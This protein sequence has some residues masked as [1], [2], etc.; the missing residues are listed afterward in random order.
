MGES[1]ALLGAA[2]DG[3]EL[4]VGVPAPEL[5]AGSFVAGPLPA[6]ISLGSVAG[7]VLLPP[8]LPLS[9]AAL[10]LT[11][12]GCPS[13]VFL[14]AEVLDFATDKASKS[15]LIPSYLN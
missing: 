3:C 1:L 4:S 11:E 9:A 10:F 8:A 5:C 14:V 7:G 13:G 2:D 6:A 15:S 12:S